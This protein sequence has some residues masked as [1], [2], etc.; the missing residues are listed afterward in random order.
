MSN[1][2]QGFMGGGGGKPCEIPPPP[3]PKIEYFLGGGGGEGTCPQTPLA[4]H[5][6]KSMCKSR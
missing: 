5:A 3:P 4:I 6:S 2:K 1:H